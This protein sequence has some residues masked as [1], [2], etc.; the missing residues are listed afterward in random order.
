MSEII[1]NGVRYSTA[2]ELARA[3]NLKPATVWARLYRG[4][5]PEEAVKPVKEKVISHNGVEYQ[6]LRELC[7]ENGVPF[8]L[9]RR[10]KKA[11]RP[12]SECL[13]PGGGAYRHLGIVVTVDNMTFSSISECLRYYGIARTT[14]ERRIRKGMRFRQAIGLLEQ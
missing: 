5:T 9:Y 8:S 11:G 4:A 14:Y 2:S 1:C 13:I 3:F 12:L 6:S 7:K 10:R